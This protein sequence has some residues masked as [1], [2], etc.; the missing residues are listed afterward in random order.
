MSL[1]ISIK[2]IINQEDAKSLVKYLKENTNL[3][4]DPFGYHINDFNQISRENMQEQVIKYFN[5][6]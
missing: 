6:K 4:F 2:G 5:N 3:K 1:I